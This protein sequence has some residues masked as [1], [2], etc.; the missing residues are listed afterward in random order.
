MPRLVLLSDTHG[1]HDTLQV[2]DGDVLVHAGDLSGTGKPREIEAFAR[3]IG[4]Q[5]HA[6]KIVIA[7]NHDFLF[8]REPERAEALLRD[9]ATY[10]RDSEI[11]AAGL[12]FWGSPWQPWFHDWA[13]N[14][15]R[16]A[17][18]AEK[19]AL[20]PDGIDVLVTHGPPFGILDRVAYGGQSVG[21]E[22]LLAA[23]PR[24][25]PK[26]HVFGHI[27]EAYGVVHRGGTLYVNASTCDLRYVPVN[28]PVV[29]DVEGGDWRIVSKSV[30]DPLSN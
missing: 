11:T 17:A 10:L 24:I 4:R 5:T 26:L 9:H 16:G 20:V 19:W 23:L 8:E 6:H 13:F 3:F 30:P 18:L 27:H 22:A 12:R 29:V 2:P 21:C 28:P 15:S 1:L 14:L 7:G 25:A